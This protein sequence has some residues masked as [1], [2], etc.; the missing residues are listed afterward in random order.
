MSDQYFFRHICLFS[1]R[2][3]FLCFEY[4]RKRDLLPL[5]SMRKRLQNDRLFTDCRP[6]WH[7][8]SH[9]TMLSVTCRSGNLLLFH[10]PSGPCCCSCLRAAPERS[11][12][13]SPSAALFSPA[14]LRQRAFPTAKHIPKS[15]SGIQNTK[16]AFLHSIAFIPCLLRLEH[17]CPAPCRSGKH[18]GIRL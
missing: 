3:L 5:Q 2:S 12:T 14:L 8:C 17:S 9:G 10:S 1:S 15:P 18:W 16:G 4:K 11:N 13:R 7:G 6:N